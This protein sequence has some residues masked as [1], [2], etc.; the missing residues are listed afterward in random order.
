[1]DPEIHN[2]FEYDNLQ[3]YLPMAKPMAYTPGMMAIFQDATL[4]PAGYYDLCHASK[5]SPSLQA[6]F[7][8]NS[9]SELMNQ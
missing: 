9:K 5:A 3:N 4:L 2:L 1:M 7:T 6:D 8:G